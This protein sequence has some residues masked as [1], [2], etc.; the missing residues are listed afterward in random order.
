MA[1]A[2]ARV[3]IDLLHQ[4]F[5]AVH[6]VAHDARGIAAGGGHQLVADHQQTKVV[7][8]QVALYQD[9]VVKFAS[10]VK[11]G[12]QVVLV[13]DVDGHALAL[14]AVF[15]L[16]DHG[17]ANFKSGCPSVL[18]VVYLTAHG[19]G[20]ARSGQQFF[21][22]LFVLRYLLRNGARGVHFGGLNAPLL[23]APT[24]L[25]HAARG[26]AAVWNAPCHGS[27]GNSSGTGAQAFVFIQ[28]T[29]LVQ[30]GF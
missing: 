29:Q 18:G 5:H 27:I 6:A 20:H 21:G 1:R 13:V 11:C 25:N 12:V 15:G 23:A 24:K 28:L 8:G 3:F 26:H 9:V 7:A 19:H 2:A 14:V 4:F 22:Q 10:G 30:G 16:D 17:Q